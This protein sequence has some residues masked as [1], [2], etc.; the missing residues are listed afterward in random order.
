MNPPPTP[1]RAR[2]VASLPSLK[3]LRL[4][5]GSSLLH[6]AVSPPMVGG[7]EF[8]EVTLA[9]IEG[10]GVLGAHQSAPDAPS[11]WPWARALLEDGLID[12]DFRLTERAHRL[13]SH[14]GAT[15][16]GIETHPH[17]GA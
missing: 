6:A 2:P 16:G 14:R 13:L 17:R 10:V 15:H 11:V 8:Q 7:V 4:D 3:G 12:R 1:P 5:P 9:P